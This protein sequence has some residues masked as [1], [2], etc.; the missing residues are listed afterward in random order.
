MSVRGKLD[1][2]ER[3]HKVLNPCPACAVNAGIRVAMIEG[4]EPFDESSM[5]CRLCGTPPTTLVVVQMRPDR[6]E[7]RSTPPTAVEGYR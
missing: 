1:R 2:L 3:Q 7:S 4:D 6:A 5:N